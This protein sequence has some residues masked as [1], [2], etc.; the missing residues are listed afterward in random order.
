[1]NDKLMDKKPT[2]KELSHKNTRLGRA[3]SGWLHPAGT[4]GYEEIYSSLFENNSYVM[5]LSDPDDLSI[6]DAN[7]AAVSYYGWSHEEMIRKKITDINILGEAKLRQKAKRIA[8]RK[9]GHFF[10]R[11]RLSNGTIRDVEV[12]SNPIVLNG[13]TLL[14]SIVHD[15]TDR[16][17]TDDALMSSKQKLDLHF[18]QTPLAVIEWDLEFKVQS[19]NPA[20]EKIFGYTK[21]EIV[22]KHA[23]ILLLEKDRDRIDT[24]LKTLFEQKDGDRTTC[25]NITRNGDRLFCEWFNTPII[26]KTGNPIA[27]FSLVQDITRRKQAEQA[28]QFERDKFESMI[29]CIGDNLYIV[30][31]NYRIEFQNNASRKEFGDLAGKKC[32][33]FFF[34]HNEPCDFCLMHDTLDRNC[35]NQVEADTENKKNY[36]IIFSPFQDTQTKCVVVFRDITEK[37]NLQAEAVRAGH[38][39]SLG[40]L[41]AGVA[42]EINNPVTG[43]ISI[44][45]VLTDKFKELGGDQKIPEMIVREGERISSIVKNLLSFARDK[46]D[47]LCPAFLNDVLLLAIELMERQILKDGIHLSV[48]LSH[49]NPI[50]KARNQELQQVFINIISNARY[51]INRK[52]PDPH[53]NKTLEIKGETLDI[54]GKQYARL[55]F[56]D[57]GIGIPKT[58][59]DKI[60]NPFFST[61]PHGEGTGLG[62]SISHGIIESHGGRL[63]FDSKEGEYTKVMVDLPLHNNQSLKKAI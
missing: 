39:A 37:K 47:E 30:N 42:H 22:G 14:Y 24:V 43:I 31:R 29:N 45:E 27:L 58:L 36:E 49:E 38:L 52:Y 48:N 32:F 9:I 40:E 4:T 8:D 54:K 46:K 1:M 19:W 28:V 33:K 12:Y 53:K 21:Q 51:A 7:L 5:L 13:K 62:L 26:N 50:I 18:L 23:S 63:W 59:V 41:A 55:I 25:M 34:G 60:I 15:I 10:F 17:K 57:K 35:I 11:H 3:D 16:K 6:V 56:F 44:A 20:A 61:K 2:D